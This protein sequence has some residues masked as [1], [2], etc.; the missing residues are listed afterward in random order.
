[1]SS[2]LQVILK[3]FKLLYRLVTLPA[4]WIYALA[5][6]GWHWLPRKARYGTLAV[7]VV[8]LGAFYGFTAF[9]G[10]NVNTEGLLEAKRPI[11]VVTLDKAKFYRLLNQEQQRRYGHSALR[12]QRRALKQ[13]GVV[14]RIEPNYLH[15]DLGVLP[16]DALSR[17]WNGVVSALQGA[18]DGAD[19]ASFY[20]T[21]SDTIYVN[22]DQGGTLKHEV[23]HA[24]EDQWS[25]RPE[26]LREAA[27]TDQRLA[28]KAVIEGTALHFGGGKGATEWY[29][30]DF[31]QDS[32]IFIYRAGESYLQQ[33]GSRDLQSAFELTPEHTYPI[34][35]GDDRNQYLR[36]EPAEAASGEKRL[37]SDELG[38]FGVY[39]Y[40]L[41]AGLKAEDV[42]LVSAS[43]MGDRIDHLGQEAGERRTVWRLYFDNPQAVRLFEE[44]LAERLGHLPDHVVIE[45]SVP[46]EAS[47]TSLQSLDKLQASL[48]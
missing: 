12:C 22:R 38:A 3:P 31:D 48:P 9:E 23:V 29:T 26:R 30:G 32:W 37:C 46:E 45:P 42:A 2:F 7:G 25:D 43:W 6:R 10:G 39:S 33:R 15:P 19:V 4:E 20:R 40:L 14:D 47:G 8:G 35:T 24:L 16:Q 18:L 13:L 44:A 5:R 27:T 1:M 34:L 17:A 28:L 11:A 41:A 21:G 36:P